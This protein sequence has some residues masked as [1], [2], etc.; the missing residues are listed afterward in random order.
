MSN[1]GLPGKNVTGG[2]NAGIERPIKN[3]CA[4]RIIR[5][6]MEGCLSK[7][8]K[9]GVYEQPRRVPK[10]VP[11]NKQEKSNGPPI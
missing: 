5:R 8:R 9:L 1:I 3:Q 2:A 11:G 7:L 4:L 6:K 10:R